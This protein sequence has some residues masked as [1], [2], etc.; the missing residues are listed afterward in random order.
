M[1]NVSA[2][3]TMAGVWLI[4][5]LKLPEMPV[6]LASAVFRIIAAIVCAFASSSWYFYVGNV[7]ACPSILI[8]PLARSQISKLVSPQEV[9]KCVLVFIVRAI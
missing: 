3:W 5:V 8:G 4:S 7:L 9:G 6:S 1:Y 2:I